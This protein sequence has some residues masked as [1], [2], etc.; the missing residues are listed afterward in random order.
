MENDKLNFDKKYGDNIIGVD[1]AGRGPL[2]GEVVAAAVKL[3]VYNEEL[4]KI[5]DS[6]KLSEKKR[7]EIYDKI[8]QYFDVGIGIASVEEIDKYNILNATFLAM[9]RAIE[10]LKIDKNDVDIVLVDGNKKI[11]NCEYSQETVVKGD[12]KSLAIGA[13]SI[14]A[15]VWRDRLMKNLSEEFPEYHF[16]KHKGY[17]TKL[18]R[19]KILELGVLPIHRKTFLGKIIKDIEVKK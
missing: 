14:V 2:A 8:F 16:E 15:K 3:K 5:D 17:G 12:S 1:E 7:E 10:N 13:A 18:H 6:K 9:N 19:E 11:K 4:E